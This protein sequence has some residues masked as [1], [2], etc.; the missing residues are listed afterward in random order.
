MVS[1]NQIKRVYSLQ[2]KKYR[3]LHNLF[4]VEGEKGV[5][6]FLNSEYK[7]HALFCTDTFSVSGFEEEIYRVSEKDLKKLSLLKTPNKVLALFYQ[8]PQKTIVN[9]GFTLVLDN[10]KDPGNLGTIIRLCDWFNV[11]QLICS[12]ETVD[13]YNPKVVQATM[14]SLTRV[15]I[16]YTDILEVI[17]NTKRPCFVSVMDGENI[18][19][20]DIPNEAILIMGNEANGISDK[21]IKEIDTHLTI[22]RFNNSGTP[23]SL[24]VATA[25]AILLSEFKRPIIQKKN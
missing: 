22:P 10:V 16:V 7:L 24:N 21:I 5:N 15:S 17:K 11:T 8:I 2:Q 3:N 18:Y 13:C 4:V 23:E 25:T 12:P 6:E 14:G 19:S 9:K 1:K 20:A